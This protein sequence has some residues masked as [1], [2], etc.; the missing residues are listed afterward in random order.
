M[1]PSDTSKPE[2]PSP[3]TLAVRHILAQSITLQES[4]SDFRIDLV[5][6]PKS[7]GIWL[8]DGS[9]CPSIGLV[10]EPGIGGY[11]QIY[12]KVSTGDGLPLA[13]NS[14]SIQLLSRDQT[15]VTIPFADLLKA[16]EHVRSAAKDTEAK[17]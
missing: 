6:F 9:R 7:V 5:A 3:D 15:Q 8:S 17:A 11:L 14:E 2:V 12:D 10:V 16:V 13:I 1:P 4:G